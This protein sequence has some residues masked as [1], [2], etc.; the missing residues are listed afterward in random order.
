M[1][2]NFFG[3][4][5]GCDELA[6][7]SKKLTELIEM[8]ETYGVSDN[9]LF[10]SAIK[11]YEL[12]L[13]IIDKIKKELNK[14]SGDG[15]LTSKEYVKGRENICVNP[16]VKELPKHSDSANKTAALILNIIETLGKEPEFDGKLN[17]LKNE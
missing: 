15:L 9:A 16:L 13:K 11:Q 14:S 17:Q 4:L 5:K 6:R 1:Y 8:A 2:V 7:N 3:N 12:Q 10:L